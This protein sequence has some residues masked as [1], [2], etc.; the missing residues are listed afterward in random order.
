[1]E[2]YWSDKAKNRSEWKEQ[3]E[4]DLKAYIS[5]QKWQQL[6]KWACNISVNMILKTICADTPCLLT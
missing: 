1:M 5:T 2:N 6:V 3:S 4:N